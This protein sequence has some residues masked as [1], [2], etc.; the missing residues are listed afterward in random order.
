[1]I[2]RGLCSRELYRGGSLIACFELSA[3]RGERD[4]GRD[5]AGGEGG[6]VVVELVEEPL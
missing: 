6:P 5:F 4:I 3:A 1:M 2:V